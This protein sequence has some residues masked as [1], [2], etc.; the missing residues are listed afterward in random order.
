MPDGPTIRCRH[1][2]DRCIRL[3][4]A[5]AQPPRAISPTA[6]ASRISADAYDR[7]CVDRVGGVAHRSSRSGQRPLHKTT[8]ALQTDPPAASRGGPFDSD[9]ST[10]SWTLDSWTIDSRTQTMIPSVRRCRTAPTIRCRHQRDRCIRLPAAGAQPS[11]AISPTATASR[12]SADAYGRGCVDRVGGVAHRSSRSGQRPLH[13]IRLP[14]RR[15]HRPHRAAALVRVTLKRYS[16][17]SVDE[18]PDS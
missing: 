15:I 5:G 13:K 6:T 16:R 8:A 7:G 3:P 12:I 10:D 4:A 18:T 1:R 9:D 2:R 14:C 17:Q 11:R